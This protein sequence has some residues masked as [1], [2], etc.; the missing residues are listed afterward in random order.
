MRHET[1][2]ENEGTIVNT[3]SH[4]DTCKRNKH[5]RWREGVLHQMFGSCVQH[6]RK[7]WIQL[8]L[9]FCEKEGSKRSKINEKGVNWIENQG[10]N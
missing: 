9:R 6:A 8:D 1:N 7:N 2:Y 3:L 10:K 4:T 5:P